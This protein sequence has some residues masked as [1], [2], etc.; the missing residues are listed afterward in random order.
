MP[1]FDQSA[2]FM[3]AFT[4]GYV[5]QA[6]VLVVVTQAAGRNRVRPCNTGA[7]YCIA[8]RPTGS[9][10]RRRRGFS[11]SLIC[12]DAHDD[13]HFSSVP[14]IGEDSELR[15]FAAGG[16]TAGRGG[17]AAVAGAEPRWRV[18][19]DRHSGGHS[20]ERVEGPLAGRVGNGYSGPVVAQGRVFVTD[21][22]VSPEVER[23]L[24]FE[25]ATGKPLWA[26]SYPCDYAEH[27]I[28]Q[29]P[30]GLADGPRRQGLHAGDQGASGL[31]RCGQGR[32][33]L[34]EGPGEG[35]QRPRPA[36]WGQRGPAGRRRSA[37]RRAPAA[38]PMRPSSPS[39]ATPA[40]ER[41]KAL[42]DRPAY[43]A[44]IV[45][46]RRRHAGKSIV[47]TADTIT[48]LEPA[49]G[50]VLWQVPYKATFD[51]AQ[52]VA[53]PV[54]HKDLLLCLAAW[55]RGSMMLKLDPDK[56]AASVLWKT[57]TR[58]TTTISTPLFQDDRHFY[59]IESDG[60][61]VLPGCGHRR[62]RCGPRASR[63]A[64]ARAHAHLTPNGDRVFLF[65][66]NGPPHP[67]AADARRDIRNSAA[68]LLVE[69]T[70]G[71]RR[72]QPGDLGAPGLCQQARLRPQRSGA[73]V[74]FAR[75]RA[76]PGRESWTS[77][78]RR[79][80][81]GC[82]PAPRGRERGL[83]LAFSPDGKTLALGTG[84]GPCKLLELSTGK[85]L[86]APARHND[87][88]CSVAFSPDGKLLVSA[89]G[90]E[91]KPAR[92]GDKTSR[93]KSSCGTWPRKQNAASLPAT[94]T[95]SSLPPFRP[96]A[97]RWPPAAPIR[98]SGCGTWRR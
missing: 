74:C 4:M 32:R 40:S 24:C 50:K 12:G 21:R 85:E 34:E 49:T 72:G 69:P 91:F 92:N 27:G 79:S 70:A 87:W 5:C 16:G 46:H 96:T 93:A 6:G 84:R 25:E 3:N 45:D 31:S 81:P 37:H 1:S 23:V 62:Q 90:S 59:A 83:G 11:C 67:G 68:C 19:R 2:G 53:S 86:P 44:P 97:R 10:F 17:L 58:P 14:K 9:C 66:Q 61:L 55:N 29:R 73:G 38:S 78:R 43:S 94:R 54:V 18:A 15:S 98:P 41:W 64:A 89:G 20:R 76:D 65:N 36:I 26:H 48:A 13:L 63:P 82:S 51:P 8:A 22:Q 30:A 88:V 35:V 47:W 60:S 57:R 71:Y 52:A 42:E 95:R 75:R 39:T 80:S 33:G 7:L 77:R 28:R 56:P